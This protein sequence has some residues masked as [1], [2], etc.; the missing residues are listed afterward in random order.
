MAPLLNPAGR[1]HVTDERILSLSTGEFRRMVREVAKFDPDRADDLRLRRRRLRNAQAEERAG[2][3]ALQRKRDWWN[4]VGKP[5]RTERLM[6]KHYAMYEIPQGEWTEENPNRS[7]RRVWIEVPPL[8]LEGQV[9]SGRDSFDTS[10]RV[11][12]LTSDGELETRPRKVGSYKSLEG[13]Q[14]AAERYRE[15]NGDR[16]VQKALALQA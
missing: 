8:A 2:E 6:R 5:R 1:K 9:E 7:W 12:D 13:A 3:L 14:R 15:R 4:R 10:V 16:L 11:I